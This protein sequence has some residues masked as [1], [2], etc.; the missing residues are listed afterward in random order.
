MLFLVLY[1]DDV[2]TLGQRFQRLNEA[3]SRYDQFEANSLPEQIR[4]S[5]VYSLL[6]PRPLAST[7]T[8]LMP[9]LFHF[10]SPGSLEEINI[11]KNAFIAAVLIIFNLL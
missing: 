2:N 4:E 8:S 1:K 5:C 10:Q 9:G 6:G 7:Q 3:F 11:N